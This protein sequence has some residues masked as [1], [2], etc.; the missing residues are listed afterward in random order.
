MSL[1]Q[2]ISAEGTRYDDD[3]CFFVGERR[4]RIH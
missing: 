1:S 3:I 2:V 4:E